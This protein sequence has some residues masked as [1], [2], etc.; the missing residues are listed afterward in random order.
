MRSIL[1]CAGQGSRLRDD[2]DDPI[3]VELRRHVG[4][5]RFSCESAWVNGGHPTADTGPAIDRP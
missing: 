4:V 1:E 2:G 5:C 3:E